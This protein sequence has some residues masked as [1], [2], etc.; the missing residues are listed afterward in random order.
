M[1]H[2]PDGWVGLSTAENG[3]Y[4]TGKTFLPAGRYTVQ[5]ASSCGI[6][7]TSVG[8]WAPQWY[9]SVYRQSQAAPV[10]IRN[11]KITTGISGCRG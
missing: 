7:T 5:F 11:G 10:V 4:N 6:G 2:F 1:V 8:N 3:T 9:R